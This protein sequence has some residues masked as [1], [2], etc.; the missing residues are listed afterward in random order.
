VRVIIDDDSQGIIYAP[1]M[2]LELMRSLPAHRLRPGMI[3]D[4]DQLLFEI[5]RQQPE[6]TLRV[7]RGHLKALGI[8]P[9]TKGLASQLCG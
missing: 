6:K 5:T 9:T 7:A 4:V 2:G 8:A 1:A 3:H